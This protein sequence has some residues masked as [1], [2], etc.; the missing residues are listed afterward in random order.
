MDVYT[1]AN[2]CPANH[3]SHSWTDNW[4]TEISC[5]EHSELLL[6]W[7][8]AKLVVVEGVIIGPT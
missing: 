3:G 8:M 2:G 4:I 1:T 5:T 7:L 6:V